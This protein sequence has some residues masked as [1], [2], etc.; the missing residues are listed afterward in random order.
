MTIDQFVKDNNYPQVKKLGKLNGWTYYIDATL[1]KEEEVG[2][3]MMLKEKGSVVLACDADES[4]YAVK[5]F[6]SE[7]K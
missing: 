7:D 2:V 3:P 1:V 5:I 6:C 4:L